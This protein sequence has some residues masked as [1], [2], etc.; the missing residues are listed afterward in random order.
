MRT[1]VRLK[2]LSL[3]LATGAVGLIATG[4]QFNQTDWIFWGTIGVTVLSL[5]I[6]LP[7]LFGFFRT[8]PLGTHWDVTFAAL[9]TFAALFLL[10]SY[11]KLDNKFWEWVGGLDW[12]RG[13]PGAI[14]A[15]GQVIIA[16]L[17]VW[18]ASRQNEITEKLT[19]QQNII[20]QQ[21]TIDAYFQGISDL[22]IDEEGQME[23]W[24]L[25]RVIAEAR[26]AALLGRVDSG[27]RAKVIRFLSSANLLTPLK[28]DGLL[29]R[30]ILDGS[31]GYVIDLEHGVRVINLSTMLAGQ[32]LSRT[33][34]RR[35]ILSGANMIRTNFEFTNL[36]GA[37]FTG[38]ILIGANLRGTDLS[39]V[40]FFH[41]LLEHA[42]PRNRNFNPNFQTGAYTGAVVDG[43]DVTGAKGLSEENRQYL[44]A[45]GGSETRKTIP[46]GCRDVP[47][48]LGL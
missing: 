14:G 12:E 47:N 31:G 6:L 18:V 19:S 43:V 39:N 8:S 23:D 35:A 11:T 15:A 32:D 24:P 10:G 40:K 37:D 9:I 3:I 16:I 2:V 38:T 4:I 13:V 48:R 17:A 30:P 27:G 46:G 7:F 5:P 42:S 21:Q 29:G 36:A 34:L 44:C 45:W 1:I 20:T 41:G 25:E 22:V 26:T 33:D 28:R